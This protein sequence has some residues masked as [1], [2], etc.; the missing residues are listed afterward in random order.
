MT[1]SGIILYDGDCGFCTRVTQ[2][3]L[4]WDRRGRLRA[5]PIASREGERLLPG[6]DPGRRLA[7]WHLRTADGEVHS[8]GAAVPPLMR[9]LPGG[10]PLAAL[11]SVFP[12]ATERVYRWVAD[13]RGRLGRRVGATACGTFSLPRGGSVA[14]A[15]AREG[16]EQIS[17]VRG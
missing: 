2:G 3:I 16:T 6:V 11:A 13:R 14:K 4:A 10:A 9:L 12:A 5:V 7:S 15:R 1:E 8:A 17:E